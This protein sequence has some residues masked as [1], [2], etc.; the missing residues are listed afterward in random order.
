MRRRLALLAPLL[1]LAS[2]GGG[3]KPADEI[4]LT[5]TNDGYGE[6]WTIRPDG[7]DRL[8]LT[9][10]APP[11]TDAAG[12]STPAWSHDGMRLAYTSDTSDD[13]RASDVYVIR[14]DGKDAR[15]VT[16]DAAA[17]DPSWS[18]DGEQIAYERVLAPRGIVVVNAHGGNATQLTNVAG[19]SF[20]TA[21][22]WSPDGSA[23]AYTRTT[24]TSDFEHPTVAIYLVGRE[25]GGPK[26]LLDDAAEPAWSPDG[27][28][29]AFTSIRDHFGRTCFEDCTTSGEIYVASSDGSGARRLTTS[30]ANDHSP[31]W[32]PDGRS[33]AFVSDR[34]DPVLHDYELYV[35][36]ADGSEL[37][38]LTSGAAWSLDPA[39]RP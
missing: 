24:I 30:K 12:A 18:P 19:S 27:E 8:R 16:T 22:A 10:A 33:I 39:W 15:R 4:A 14:A 13:R 11:K 9:A 35:M 17:A 29:M 38:R 20:D 2:C 3:A 28:R 23:V 36:R 21:P 34:S 25:V 6:I 37:R 1:L 5:A 31:A 26:K 7:S 32:S